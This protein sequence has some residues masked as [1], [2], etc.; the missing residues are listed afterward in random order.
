M[1]LLLAACRFTDKGTPDDTHTT[2]DDTGT[3]PVTG[4]LHVAWGDL[5]AHTNFS[6]DGCED[7]DTDCRADEDEPAELTFSRAEAYGLQF[8]SITDHAEV[9]TYERPD[10]AVSLDIWTATQDLVNAADASRC[11]PNRAM[12][13]WRPVVRSQRSAARVAAVRSACNRRRAM[14]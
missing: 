12:C 1:L 7:P 2:A 10:D 14:W 13:A 4:T 9:T 8:T 3:P 5:H 6:H 11:R